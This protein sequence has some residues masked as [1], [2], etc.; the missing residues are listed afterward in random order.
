MA[1]GCTHEE[2]SF[3]S[4]DDLDN[5]SILLDKHND[6]EEGITHLFDD[7]THLFSFSSL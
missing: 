4:L 5:V 6:L 1:L 2:T 7:V 3:V